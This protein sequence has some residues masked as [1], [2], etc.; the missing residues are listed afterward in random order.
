MDELP[1]S[2]NASG[3]RPIQ[4]FLGQRQF[5]RD[6]PVLAASLP[7]FGQVAGRMDSPS[8]KEKGL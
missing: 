4:P 7:S 8:K 6:N 3:W 2:F 1:L 5:G